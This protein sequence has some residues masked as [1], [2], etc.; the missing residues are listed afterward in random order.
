MMRKWHM[1]QLYCEVAQHHQGDEWP[2]GNPLLAMVRLANLC[3]RRLGIGMRSDPALHL[4]AC[5]E[6]HVLG[7]K[8]V[9]LAEL[10]I[11]MEDALPTL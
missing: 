5:G 8:E 1:P 10:E 6:A 9:A 4:F 3:C 11:V 2:Q 7:L